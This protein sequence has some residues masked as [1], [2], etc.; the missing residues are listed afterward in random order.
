M[1][2]QHTVVHSTR[3]KPPISH[4]LKSI[5]SFIMGASLER[6][7]MYIYFLANRRFPGQPAGGHPAQSTQPRSP[8]DILQIPPKPNVKPFM[9]IKKHKSRTKTKSR[10]TKCVVSHKPKTKKSTLKKTEQLLPRA[11]AILLLLC[12]TRNNSSSVDDR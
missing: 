8:R 9:T 1:L 12:F 5:D 4:C 2:S 6:M 7:N 3:Q 11:L 10:L